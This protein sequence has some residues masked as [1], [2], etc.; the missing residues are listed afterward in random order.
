MPA[1]LSKEARI[2]LVYKLSAPNGQEYVGQTIRSFEQRWR[3]HVG[4]AKHPET[5]CRAVA[6]AI[7]QFGAD[8]FK[9][10]ILVICNQGDLNDYEIK[11]IALFGTL[12][13]NG[14]NLTKGGTGYSSFT[15]ESRDKSSAARR[16]HF[17]DIH[18]IPTFIMYIPESNVTS[19][20]YL[21]NLQTEPTANFCC[22]EMTLEEKYSFAIRY[23]V[24]VEQRAETKQEYI[25][26]KNQ[27]RRA[28]IQKILTIGDETFELP[29]YIFFVKREQGFMVKGEGFK[30]RTFS[31][32]KRTHRDNYNRAMAYLK[33]IS[34]VNQ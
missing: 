8:K 26:L 29:C 15:K 11:F 9:T 7:L 32:G 5:G 27:R 14:L 13:P 30:T 10:E 33:S 31:D 18:D 24:D 19:S 6:R 16:I 4:S 28:S 22:G 12:Y 20:G 2:G 17:D 3:E 21:V 23:L 25:D 34:K 1:V